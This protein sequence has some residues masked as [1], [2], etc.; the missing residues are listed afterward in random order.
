MTARLAADL[1]IAAY[2][3]RLAAANLPCYVAAKGDPTAGAVLV[4]IATLD[5][6]ARLCGRVADLEGRR[7]WE[8][9]AEGPESD[10]DAAIARQRRADPDL[11]VLE[12]E[13][14]AGGALLDDPTLA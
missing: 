5:G 4:K 7:A 12:V 6:A 8:T 2:R 10:V 1:W 14:R 11:W 9:L 3:A 13:D